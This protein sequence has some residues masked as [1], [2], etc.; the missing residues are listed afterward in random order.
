MKTGLRFLVVDDHWIARSAVSHL[1][2]RLDRHAEISEAENGAAAVAFVDAA[3]FDAAVVDLNLPGENVFD[4]IRALRSKQP[5]MGIVVLSVSE[6]REDVLQSLAAGAVGYIPKTSGPTE[7]L[8]T[9]KRVLKG[10]VSLPQRLLTVG[11]LSDGVFQADAEIERF[12]A[13]LAEFTPRQKDVVRLMGRGARNAEI[14]QELAISV[15]TVR[16]HVQAIMT[17]LDIR[18][19]TQIESLSSRSVRMRAAA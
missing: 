11:A 2:T 14:A 4:I 9:V 1:L 16:A 8:E 19:R 15:N 13:A 12:E 3:P 18:N 10:E 6:S 7:I 17:R 5:A